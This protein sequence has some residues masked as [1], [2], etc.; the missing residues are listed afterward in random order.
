MYLRRL[1][2]L[3]PLACLLIAGCASPEKLYQRAQSLEHKDPAQAMRLYTR[4]IEHSSDRTPRFLADALV[5]RGDLKLALK[6]PQAAFEDYERATQLNPQ[7]ARAHLRAANLLLVGNS[8]DRAGQEAGIVFRLEPGNADALAIMGIAALAQD[9]VQEAM[10]ILQRVLDL[11]PE[12]GDVAIIVADLYRAQG[13]DEEAHTLLLQTAEKSPKDARLR[14]S[15][16]RMAE[17]QGDNAAAEQNYRLAIASD[18]S[19]E[20]NLRLAQFLQ[21]TSRLKESADVLAHID[22]IRGSNTSE[23][24]DYKL[25]AGNATQA[26]EQYRSALAKLTNSLGTTE[27]SAEIKQQYAALAARIIEA[28]LQSASATP[29]HIFPARLHLQQF[30]T[31]FDPTTAQILGAEIALVE[32]DTTSALAQARSAVALSSESA[33]AHYLLAAASARGG[34][35]A[36]AKSETDAAVSK[37]PGFIP[38][39]LQAAEQA[40]ADGN[41]DAAEIHAAFVVRSEPANLRGLLL[42]ARI[43]AAQKRYLPAI[44]MARRALAVD[45][46]SAEAHCIQGAI[47]AETHNVASALIEYQQAVVLAPASQEAIEGLVNV[48]RFG[49]ITRPMLLRMERVASNPPSSATLM[50]TAG[51]LFAQNGWYS[52]AQRCLRAAADIDP[53]RSAALTALARSYLDSGNTEAAQ[54]AIAEANRSWAE[55]LEGDQALRRDDVQ[56]ATRSFESALHHGENSGVT[57]NNLAWIYA[58]RSINLDRAL[59]LAQFAHQTLPRDLGVMDTLGYVYLQRREYNQA[60]VI[61]ENALGYQRAQHIDDAPVAELRQHL[62]EAYRKA[63]RTSDAEALSR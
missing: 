30:A 62:A 10:P 29:D 15:L 61:L 36:T 51:R 60:I 6:D 3:V 23:V 25:N 42:Y 22:A 38:A 8:P 28:D 26:G 24:A 52:D 40:L 32:G 9:R 46:S 53:Q 56:S 14:V 50:E 31:F 2:P 20:T 27:P 55:L 41:P 49:Q 4:V 39:R 58:Q 7:N 17:E 18:N 13:R 21:R 45:A 34:D 16:A 12:R 63:G 48:Y 43:L 47:D 33:A 54:R 59:E 5:S 37:D 44:M 57:A 1:G 19:A 35:V 11:R